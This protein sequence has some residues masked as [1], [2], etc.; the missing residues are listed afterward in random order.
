MGNVGKSSRK[1]YYVEMEMSNG[2]KEK[3]LLDGNIL[4]KVKPQ[5]YNL[6]GPSNLKP[7]QLGNVPNLK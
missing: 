3:F 6:I 7:I 4:R 2:V 1:A 5:N